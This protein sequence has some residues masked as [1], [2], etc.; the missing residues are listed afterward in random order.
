MHRVNPSWATD[1]I[2]DGEP[3]Y[4]HLYEMTPKFPCLTCDSTVSDMDSIMEFFQLTGIPI[5]TFN[6]IDTEMPDILF[7]LFNAMAQK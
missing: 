4:K 5:E 1:T 6:E 3:R 2:P 7:R